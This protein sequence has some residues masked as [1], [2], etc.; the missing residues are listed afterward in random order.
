MQ[1]STG[2]KG[3]QQPRPVGLLILSECLVP[4]AGAGPAAEGYGRRRGPSLGLY[5]SPLRRYQPRRHS[6]LSY[7]LIDI[8]SSSSSE[9][10]EAVTAVFRWHVRF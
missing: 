4:P 10:P 1:T 6:P 2:Q 7:D 8:S 3:S 9:S 5:A